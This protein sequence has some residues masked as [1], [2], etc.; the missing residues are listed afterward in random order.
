MLVYVENVQAEL[1]DIMQPDCEILS[2]F[3]FSE[4]LDGKACEKESSFTY[5][6]E[7][8]NKRYSFHFPNWK[9]LSMTGKTNGLLV[10]KSLKFSEQLPS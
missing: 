4:G 8:E 6:L 5:Y 7:R 1:V 2:D 3:T 9:N 10:V